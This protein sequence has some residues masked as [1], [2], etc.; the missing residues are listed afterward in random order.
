MPFL[1]DSTLV[2]DH[3]EN[4]PGSSQCLE[5]LAEEGIAISIITYLVLSPIWKLS[6]G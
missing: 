1:I 5:Q 3:L 6:R 2:I 4:V